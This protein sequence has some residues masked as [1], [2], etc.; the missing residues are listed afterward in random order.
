V[1]PQAAAARDQLPRPQQVRGC[2]E[3]RSMPPPRAAPHTK[4]GAMPAPPRGP[5]GRGGRMQLELWQRGYR[6]AS[7]TPSPGGAS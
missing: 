1:G 5:G 4:H 2:R 3:G 7:P 6:S